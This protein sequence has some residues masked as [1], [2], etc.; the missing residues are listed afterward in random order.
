MSSLKE[1]PVLEDSDNFPKLPSEMGKL[2]WMEPFEY[3]WVCNALYQK[4]ARLN[5]AEQT[6]WLNIIVHKL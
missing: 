4:K 2:G 6:H 3:S 1:W 5:G